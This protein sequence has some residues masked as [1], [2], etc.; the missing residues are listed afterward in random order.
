[1]VL[2][3]DQRDF[4]SLKGQQNK[5]IR[6]ALPGLSVFACEVKRIDSRAT[7]TPSHP[8]LCAQAGGAL[9]V[10]PVPTE[11]A[12]EP[13]FELLSP[14]FDV[15]LQLDNAIAIELECGQRGRGFF[16]TC[17]QSLGSYF[18]LAASDWLKSK[19]E[20]ATQTAAF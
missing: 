15:V 13:A 16:L 19:I 10:R 11:S 4:E 8:S 12:D 3:I 18:Y 7:Q 2:S 14:R 17:E 1:V 20:V 6:V 5:V 9:P